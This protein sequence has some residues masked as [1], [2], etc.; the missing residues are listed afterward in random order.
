MVGCRWRM[1]G[2]ASPPDAAAYEGRAAT[3]AGQVAAAVL[4]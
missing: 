3:A 1:G 4:A 2:A